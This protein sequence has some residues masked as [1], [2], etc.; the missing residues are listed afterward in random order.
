MRWWYSNFYCYVIPV[1][2]LTKCATE[3]LKRCSRHIKVQS[4]VKNPFVMTWN[5]NVG[6]DVAQA[7]PGRGHLTCWPPHMPL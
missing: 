1:H 7:W 3:V 4:G 5:T 2:E 6:I